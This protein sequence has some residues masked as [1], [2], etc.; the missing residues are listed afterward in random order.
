VGQNTEASL[1]RLSSEA[2]E[3][4]LKELSGLLPAR[5]TE[6]LT[7]AG[8][9]NLLLAAEGEN[10]RLLLRDDRGRVRAQTIIA[11]ASDLSLAIDEF[12]R[13]NRLKRR[14]VALGL[15]LPAEK[16]FLREI[17]LPRE[18]GRSVAQVAFNDLLQ[19]TPLRAE[20]IHSTSHA[21]PSGA[22]LLVRQTVIRRKYVEDALAAIDLDAAE[23]DFVEMAALP[24]ASAHPARLNVR[25]RETTRRWLPQALLSLAAIATLS[26]IAAVAIEHQNRET[27]LETLKSEMAA[28]Q[29]QAQKVRSALDATNQQAASIT[30]L[31]SR[32]LDGVALVDL[33]E[34]ISR[35]LPDESWVQELKLS[36]NAA[37]K[38][39]KVTMS[40][41]SPAAANLVELF[42]RSAYFQN[43]ALTGPISLDPVEKRERFILE[44]GLRQAVAKTSP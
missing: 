26:T 7:D 39:Y 41:F 21:I 40:G 31:R 37:A 1:A 2:A 33:W 38:G 11:R 4:W 8:G 14:D 32:K 22:R 15:L 18:V 35:I 42:D 34:E 44:A 20:E 5:L 16:F 12:L 28:A 10:I 25:D 17:T 27:T 29:A 23:V 9:R 30:A 43:V 24:A 3:W 19:N 6:W 36:K 13:R